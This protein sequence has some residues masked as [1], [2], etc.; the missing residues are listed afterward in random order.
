VRVLIAGCGYVGS[1][2]A[3]MLAAEGHEAFGLRRRPAG[4]PPG[5]R[6]V[7]A[8]L[9][10]RRALAA[11]LPADLDA[12]VY[13][14]LDVRCKAGQDVLIDAERL[15]AKQRLSTQL[16]KYTLEGRRTGLI[17]AVL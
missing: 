10:D 6:P 1:V 14:F 17:T 5:V 8:D 16:E 15:G 3:A 12:V 7:A 4:L 9:C 11:A 2:L 13:D